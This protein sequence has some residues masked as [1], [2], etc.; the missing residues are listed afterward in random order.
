MELK[1]LI[2]GAV[3]IFMLNI[4]AISF[5]SIRFY[6]DNHLNNLLILDHELGTTYNER[7]QRLDRVLTFFMVNFQQTARMTAC[8][9]WLERNKKIVLVTLIFTDIFAK[10]EL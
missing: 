5:Y 9:I 7:F 6:L 8:G 1:E 10:L 2:T 3:F 4:Y